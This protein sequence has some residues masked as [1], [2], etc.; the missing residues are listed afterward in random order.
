MVKKLLGNLK[1]FMVKFAHRDALKS[2]L[3][4]K[5]LETLKFKVFLL[6]IVHQKR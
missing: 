2:H 3:K 4:V 5:N 6:Q 1:Y